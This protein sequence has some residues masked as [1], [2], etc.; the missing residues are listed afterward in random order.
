LRYCRSYS[1]QGESDFTAR[2]LSP[3]LIQWGDIQD[4]TTLASQLVDGAFDAV[5]AAGVLPHTSGRFL[6]GI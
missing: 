3:D 5:V 1:D 4:S 6:A 2:G